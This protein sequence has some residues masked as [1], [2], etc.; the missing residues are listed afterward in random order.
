MAK[1]MLLFT[2]LSL[3]NSKL[4][5]GRTS[6]RGDDAL[7]TQHGNMPNHLTEDPHDTLAITL[8]A[9]DPGVGGLFCS[10]DIDMNNTQEHMIGGGTRDPI[11]S[12]GSWHARRKYTRIR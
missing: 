7:T 8:G 11:R 3:F 1:S 6:R 4:S 5:G 10:G 12:E 2:E 9:T